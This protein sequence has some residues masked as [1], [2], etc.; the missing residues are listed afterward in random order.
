MG[1]SKTINDLKLSKTITQINEL[2]QVKHD[3]TQIR[4]RT[5]EALQVARRVLRADISSG[6]RAER[7]R[8]RGG[9]DGRE[10]YK[11]RAKDKGLN[12]RHHHTCHFAPPSPL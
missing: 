7:A 9:N 5:C 12:K 11:R 3:E 2:E 10:G 4:D 1:N 6:V 8:G